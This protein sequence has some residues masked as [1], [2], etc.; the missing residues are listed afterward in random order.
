M[1]IETLHWSAPMAYRREGTRVPYVFSAILVLIAILVGVFQR[2]L[3]TSILFALLG[4]M[5]AVYAR[6]ELPIID[7]EITPVGVRRGARMIPYSDILSFWMHYDPDYDI[8]ELSLQLKRWYS[9]YV[10]IQLGNQDPVQAHLYLIE[11]IPEVKHE[12]TGAHTIVRWLGL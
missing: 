7:I 12:E 1:N 11:F 6:R 3:I 8:R 9:P 5:V 10:K 4:I 2:D